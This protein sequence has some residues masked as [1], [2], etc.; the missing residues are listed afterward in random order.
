MMK[1]S[2]LPRS[3]FYK[4]L[5]EVVPGNDGNVLSGVSR[6]EKV[7]F[8]RISMDGLEG[9]YEYSKDHRMYE[10]LEVTQPPQTIVDTRKYLEN[11]MTEIGEAINGR[12]QMRW[13]VRK[14]DDSTIIGTLSLLSVDYRRQMAQWGFALGPKY[15]GRGYSFEMLELAKQYLFEKLC[16][17]RIYGWTRWNNTAV[18][19]LLLSI[20]ATEEGIG[21][22]VYRDNCG[23]YHDG[24]NYSILAYDYFSEPLKS[25]AEKERT[26]ITKEKIAE[27]I[28]SALSD[29]QV[30][31]D[32]SMETV[33][34]WNSL[35]HID[36]MLAL[37]KIFGFR[38]APADIGRARSVKAIFDLISDRNP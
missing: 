25:D 11:L 20:G 9:M 38:F 27:V 6:T 31:I 4:I 32:D 2:D 19:N 17:N 7:Y 21:R 13:F 37:E 24:W 14:S 18:I 12:T 10:Y 22:Q 8:E 34:S 26:I 23:S 3:E 5:D 33:P 35:K 28:S 29:S 15:W 1:A 30:R 36:V 16:L